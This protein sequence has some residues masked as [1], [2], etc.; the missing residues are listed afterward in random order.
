[1]VYKSAVPA[2]SAVGTLRA[3][4]NRSQP[5]IPVP[6]EANRIFLSVA[7]GACAASV[8][9]YRLPGFAAAWVA[10]AAAPNR[11]KSLRE[12]DGFI[13]VLS[14][15]RPLLLAPAWPVKVDHTRSLRNG[16]LRN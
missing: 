3:E 7:A 16:F 14:A 10:A 13:R 8:S 1:M 9:A 11:T 5:R 2:H 12:M 6:I 15:C 4:R